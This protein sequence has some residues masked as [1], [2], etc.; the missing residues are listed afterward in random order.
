MEKMD[1]ETKKL[2]P[3]ASSAST[4]VTGASA[5]ASAVVNQSRTAKQK[6]DANEYGDLAGEALSKFGI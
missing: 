1:A 5:T 2:K 6:L 4:R 3:P